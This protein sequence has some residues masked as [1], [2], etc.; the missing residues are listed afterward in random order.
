MLKSVANGNSCTHVDFCDAGQISDY[1]FCDSLL[2]SLPDHFQLNGYLDLSGSRKILR[3]PS[4][5]VVG[6]YLNIS[7]TS[8]R[9]IPVFSRIGSGIDASESDLQFLPDNYVV[10]GNLDVSYC[11]KLTQVPR[12]MK[13]L[14][15]LRA[16]YSGIRL[17]SED[18][19]VQDELDLTG[20]MVRTI[21][22]SVVAGRIM[23]SGTV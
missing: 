10:N 4:L 16:A 23:L 13:V 8:I 19:Y 18:L 3:L 12:G 1:N 21:P 20:T 17:V 14:G 11:L 15:K 22:S 7:N 5:L 9:E 2:E 6:F